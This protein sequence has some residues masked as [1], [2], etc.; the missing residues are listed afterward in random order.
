MRLVEISSQQVGKKKKKVILLGVFGQKLK[1]LSEMRYCVS[2]LCILNM[3]KHF[4]SATVLLFGEGLR[5]Q[6][7]EVKERVRLGQKPQRKWSQAHE[8]ACQQLVPENR[9]QEMKNAVTSPQPCGR[10]PV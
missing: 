4:A 5:K 2:F 6:F 3:Q 8:A 9:G 7:T 1:E 10:S